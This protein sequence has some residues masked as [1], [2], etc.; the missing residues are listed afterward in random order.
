MERQPVPP[1]MTGIGFE[2]VFRTLLCLFP[3]EPTAHR[4]MKVKSCTKWFGVF[5]GLELVGNENKALAM[6]TQFSS[7]NALLDV[8]TFRVD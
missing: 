8:R 7:R 2:T 5:S 4:D 1:F 6:E 3:T